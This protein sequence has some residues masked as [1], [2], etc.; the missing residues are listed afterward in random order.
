MSPK[1]AVVIPGRLGDIC[2]VLPCVR[3]IALKEGGKCAV[4]VSDE[5]ES[6]LDGC[7]YVEK[8]VI[9]SHFT[10]IQPAIEQARA[11]FPRVLIGKI[12][13]KSVG[14]TTQCHSFSLESWRQLGYLEQYR[15]LPL[16]FDRRDR[17]REE[18]LIKEW[19]KPE[20]MV[21]VNF[22]GKSAPFDSGD[23]IKRLFA[24]EFN[25]V[26]LSNIRAYRIYD[27]IG[28]MDVADLLVTGDTSTL[29]LAA[30]SGVPV[31]NLIGTK[32][33]TWHGSDPRNNSVLCLDYGEATR[34]E[35]LSA[36]LHSSREW[37]PRTWHVWSDYAMAGDTLRRHEVA[38]ATWPRSWI[39]L[40]VRETN[41]V[42]NDPM[43]SVPF[44]KDLIAHA[45]DCAGPRDGIV[46]TNA[47][48][49][50]CETAP[51]RV[52][53]AILEQSSCY[54]FRRDFESVQNRKSPQE[55]RAGRQYAGSDLFAFDV[56]WWNK[57][58][59]LFPDLALGAEHWDWCLRELMHTAG[60]KRFDDLAYHEYH[61]NVWERAEHRNNL[62]SQLHNK[63]LAAPFLAAHGVAFQ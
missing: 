19:G 50:V 60:G 58:G 36:M 18:K 51:K 21:L 3:D 4:V 11:M 25:V 15:R 53:E 41:R 6:I 1:T 55:I 5:F 39:D 49:C 28:L 38:K 33:T 27:L 35:K 34:T 54:S 23:D 45:I 63:A 16:V 31:I 26:D 9:S 22:S 44:I 13:E 14:V 29:H 47:D 7:S 32:P 56:A 62:P 52:E 37:R 12:N 17:K 59:R 42:I 8:V 46:L 57:H 43:R 30:A 48:T 10:D 61:Q 20:R 2:H 40:P 24:R